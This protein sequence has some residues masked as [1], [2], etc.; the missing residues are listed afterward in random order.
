MSPLSFRSASVTSESGNPWRRRIQEKWIPGL[1][2]TAH[3][4]M[5]TLACVTLTDTFRH[6][7]VDGVAR[8]MR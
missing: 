5:T 7:S 6:Q 1:R 2:L 3:P 4:G 8:D